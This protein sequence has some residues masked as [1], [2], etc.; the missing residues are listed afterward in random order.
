MDEF[1]LTLLH[2]YKNVNNSEETCLFLE[3]FL[4]DCA[5]KFKETQN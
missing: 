5:E 2:K 4:A 1:T 3:N